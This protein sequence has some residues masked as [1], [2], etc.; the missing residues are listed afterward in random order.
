MSFCHVGANGVI[1]F[2]SVQTPK[3]LYAVCSQIYKTAEGFVRCF[4]TMGN[5]INTGVFT[6]GEAP[7]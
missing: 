7:E 4:P 1:D 2:A 3:D 6:T 5:T